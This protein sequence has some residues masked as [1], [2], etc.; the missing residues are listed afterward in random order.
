MAPTGPP[1]GAAQSPAAATVT[2]LSGQERY[3]TILTAICNIPVSDA[4]ISALS[5][6]T[7]VW[8]RNY[9]G[10]SPNA[11]LDDPDDWTPDL[12]VVPSL[13]EAAPGAD[14][15]NLP[16]D[17]AEA[18]EM[19]LYGGDNPELAAFFV[20]QLFD[21][22][23]ST[24][25]VTDDDADS[26][27]YVASGPYATNGGGEDDV[28]VAVDTVPAPPVVAGPPNDALAGGGEPMWPIADGGVL[29]VDKAMVPPTRCRRRTRRR[30]SLC[31]RCGAPM[32]E[33]STNDGTMK[34]HNH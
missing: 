29:F 21:I 6:R 15:S 8:T 3:E 7:R 2:P 16:A 17:D 33:V 18:A 11:G 32:D 23:T 14:R 4:S 12:M 30:G 27:I 25:L 13:L 26:E 20:A 9:L 19:L 28:D 22:P 1:T 24:E 31:P 10:V 5:A 34:P